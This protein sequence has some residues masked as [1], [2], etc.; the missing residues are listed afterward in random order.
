MYLELFI[1]YIFFIYFNYCFIILFE[2]Y[3]LSSENSALCSPMTIIHWL[4]CFSF[5][6]LDAFPQLMLCRVVALI[7]RLVHHPQCTSYFPFGL[8][9]SANSEKS[10][11]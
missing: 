9:I 8:L 5:S 2:N 6:A 7:R 4:L 10:E 3:I 1:F 11:I